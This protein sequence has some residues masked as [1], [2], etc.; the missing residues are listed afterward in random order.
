MENFAEFLKVKENYF[1]NTCITVLTQN[2]MLFADRNQ[3]IDNSAGSGHLTLS[4]IEKLK[5]SIKVS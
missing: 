4:N 5:V 3:I 1:P 2:I